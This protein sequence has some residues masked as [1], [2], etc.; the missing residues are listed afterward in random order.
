MMMLMICDDDDD[1]NDDDDDDD[2]D[3]KWK[4]VVIDIVIVVGCG[5]EMERPITV[6]SQVWSVQCAVWSVNCNRMSHRCTSSSSLNMFQTPVQTSQKSKD[7]TRHSFAESNQFLNAKAIDGQLLE[8]LGFWAVLANSMC[9][10]K[11]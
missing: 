9:N 6:W 1:D 10:C 2:D 5:M 3:K 8:H 7:K 11:L 4:Q